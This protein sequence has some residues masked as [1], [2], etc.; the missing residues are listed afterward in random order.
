MTEYNEK[1]PLSSSKKVSLPKWEVRKY[2]SGLVVV[3]VSKHRN[4]SCILSGTNTFYLKLEASF[5]SC[6]SQDGGGD[7]VTPT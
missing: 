5:N 3:L 4:D 1:K 7:V 2:A 6:R